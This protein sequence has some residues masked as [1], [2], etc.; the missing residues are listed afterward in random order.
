MRI[1]EQDLKN[2][3]YCWWIPREEGDSDRILQREEGDSDRVLQMP[4]GLKHQDELIRSAAATPSTMR[5]EEM[6]A[7]RGA[8]EGCVCFRASLLTP[9]LTCVYIYIYPHTENL[10]HLSR[11][12]Q[13]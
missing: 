6:P 2:K 8:E 5:G 3:K 12:T 1:D 4:V 9:I 11:W 7:D 10:T 13:S